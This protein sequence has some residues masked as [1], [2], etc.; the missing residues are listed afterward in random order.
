[1]SRARERPIKAGRRYV[2]PAPGRMARRV[3]GRATV[4]VDAKTRMCVVR[5]SS[6]PPPKA[7]AAKAEMV[8]MGNCDIDANVPR[9]VVKK[10][11]VS[12]WVNVALSLRSAPAQKLVS[13]SLAKINARVDH[14]SPSLCRLLTCCVSS[15]SSCRD[16][17]LRA[18]GR[19]SESIRM[20]PQCGA[21][22]FVTFI[23]GAWAVA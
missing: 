11:D 13:I 9:S 2:P 5:A 4:V 6:R 8:G 12:S 1:M 20:L 23:A 10:L 18:A 16:I 21:G 7:G 22:T 15:V 17:A 14:W 3:S 19:L